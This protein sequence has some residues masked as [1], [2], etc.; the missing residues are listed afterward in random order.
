MLYTLEHSAIVPKAGAARWAK[1]KYGRPWSTLIE[2]AS[3]WRH[4]MPF[5]NLDEVLEPLRYTIERS[6]PG[7]HE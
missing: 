7:A 5:D 3:A 2:Q 4:G 1:E 6:R